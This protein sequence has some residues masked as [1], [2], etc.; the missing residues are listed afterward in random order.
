MLIG[1]DQIKRDHMCSRLVYTSGALSLCL[2]DHFPSSLRSSNG[3]MPWDLSHHRLS[4]PPPTAVFGLRPL[5]SS[6]APASPSPLLCLSFASPSPLLR[7]SFASLSPLLGLSPRA[8]PP[9]GHDSS[10]LSANLRQKTSLCWVETRTTRGLACCGMEQ[11][12]IWPTSLSSWMGPAC[13][14]QGWSGPSRECAG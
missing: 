6:L 1:P 8:T 7:L 10:L 12:G 11:H 4:P 14:H 13:P 5:P 3:N 9:N 2:L